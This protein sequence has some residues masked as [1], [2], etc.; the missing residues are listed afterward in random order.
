[1]SQDLR[2]HVVAA[3]QQQPN[4]KSSL[5]STQ[6]ILYSVMSLP[7][8][9]Q[10]TTKLT[11]IKDNIR[12]ND[13]ETQIIREVETSLDITQEVNPEYIRDKFS[14]YFNLS[15]TRLIPVDKLDYAIIDAQTDQARTRLAKE[16][17]DLAGDVKVLNSIDLRNRIE[18][19]S[20]A[21]V[22]TTPKTA[23]IEN[24]LQPLE[25]PYLD[26][27]DNKGE[28][29]LLLPEIEAKTGLAARGHVVSILAFVGSFKSTFALNMAYENA[30]QGKNVLY[31]SL[32]STEREMINRVVLYHMA[33]TAKQRSE[34]INQESLRDGTLNEAEIKLYNRKYNEVANNLGKHLVILD[35]LKFEYNTFAEMTNTLRAVDRQFKEDTGRGLEM[36]VV[37]QLALLKYT[38]GSGKKSTYD[39]AIM[40]DWMT[41]FREQSLNFL[42]EDERRILS[43]IVSQVRREAYQEAS[44]K[45]N[46]GRYDASAGGDSNEI[47]RTSDTM[48]TLYKDLDVKNTLLVHVPKARHG[49]AFDEP[50]QVEVYGEYFHVGQ[51]N[52]LAGE[53][54][55]V[56]S[57]QKSDFDLSSLIKK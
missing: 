32:E 56:E 53:Q 7:K 25:N 14:Y 4:T 18:G 11:F 5:T 50:L 9:D 49:A 55:T 36:L 42:Q 15:P 51:M 33:K 17:M 47:E 54:I 29:S 19:I 45:K 3:K 30:T 35:S 10:I 31:L 40:N 24:G 23:K 16:L 8:I 34:L 13:I 20:N 1:M 48:I 2:T 52:N 41:Y 38:K 26:F 46:K 21:S 57:F 44:K 37:D 12:L 43:V 22:L 6:S 28:F 39:G 27:T